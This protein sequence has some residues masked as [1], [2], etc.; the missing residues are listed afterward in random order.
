MMRCYIEKGFFAGIVHVIHKLQ[1]TWITH[2]L[3]VITS[4]EGLRRHQ[5]SLCTIEWTAV[6]LDEGQ[7]IR[8]PDTNVSSS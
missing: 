8:N 2:G 6:C 4:Y 7:K 5:D 1:H 3:A